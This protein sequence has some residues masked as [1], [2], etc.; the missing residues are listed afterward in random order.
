MTSA[1]KIRVGEYQALTKKYSGN[2]MFTDGS[3]PPNMQSIGNIPGLPE[4]THWK[5][6]F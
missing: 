5:R 2:E 1:V 6:I 3:F 4:G